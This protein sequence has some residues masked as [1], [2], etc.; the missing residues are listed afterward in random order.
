MA[1]DD[2]TVVMSEISGSVSETCERA[3]Q[4]TVI[5]SSVAT[6][7]LLLDTR[8]PPAHRPH[9]PPIP[10]TCSN[11]ACCDRHAV[12]VTQ[13]VQAPLDNSD[14]AFMALLSCCVQSCQCHHPSCR[15]QLD[16]CRWQHS[17]TQTW[18][19]SPPQPSSHFLPV[20]A[21]QSL[22][23]PADSVRPRTCPCAAACRT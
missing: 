17:L 20:P 7:W 21:L 8:S 15:C 4:V 18:A 22:P 16:C 14:D 13:P 11:R 5:E 1:E 23:P 3:G 12:Q 9:I 2:G 6:D 19:P 10:Y